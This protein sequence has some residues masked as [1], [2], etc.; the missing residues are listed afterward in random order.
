MKRVWSSLWDLR[1]HVTSV[2]A[3]SFQTLYLWGKVCVGI[4][5]VKEQ[6]NKL[7]PKLSLIHLF[8]QLFPIKKIFFLNMTSHF[9]EQ[10]IRSKTFSTNRD[11]SLVSMLVAGQS[12][13]TNELGVK[14]LCDQQVGLLG[15]VSV[16]WSKPRIKWTQRESKK[17]TVW[18]KAFKKNVKGFKLLS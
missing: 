9:Y 10:Q 14:Q 6:R 7:W 17:W 15:H 18:E 5:Y 4:M 12:S 2:C 3:H 1:T 11:E 8:S 13:F 16:W